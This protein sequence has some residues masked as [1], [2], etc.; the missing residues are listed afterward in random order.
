M[1]EAIR[2]SNVGPFAGVQEIVIPTG[3]VLIEGR[4]TNDPLKS[5]RAGKS[6]VLDLIRFA[7]YGKYRHDTKEKLIHRKANP[8]SDHVEVSLKMSHSI[9]DH[10]TIS[11]TYDSL[12][13]RYVITSPQIDDDLRQLKLVEQQ[14]YIDG[15][16]SCT[17]DE[18]EVSWM[19]RQ[20][21]SSGIMR[22]TLADRKTFLLDMFSPV[23]YPW[24]MWFKE[25][26]ERYS[27]LN[28]RQSDLRKQIVTA[29]ERL[30]AFDREKIVVT[31]E[32]QKKRRN[33]LT[34]LQNQY[35]R[36]VE[37]LKEQL[38]GNTVNK[39]KQEK[40]R[41]V[42]QRMEASS[43]LAFVKNQLSQVDTRVAELQKTV[44]LLEDS[45]QK[46]EVARAKWNDDDV[47]MV[48]TSV[49]KITRV[50]TEKMV[51]LKDVNS[52]INQYRSFIDKQK[53]CPVTRAICE[54]GESIQGQYVQMLSDAEQLERE[55]KQLELQQTKYQKAL[56]QW[57]L[58]AETISK[59][60]ANVSAVSSQVESVEMMRQNR[61]VLQEQFTQ[62]THELD[63]CNAA[64]EAA[65]KRVQ[66]AMQ[67]DDFVPRK[68]IQEI[69]TKIKQITQELEAID[70]SLGEMMGELKYMETV[71]ND[72]SAFQTGLAT[73]MARIDAL[74]SL[75]IALSK[76]GIPFFSLLESVHAFELEVNRALYQL[77]TNIR[78][79]ISVYRTLT[80]LEEHCHVCGYHY[81]DSKKKCI[82]CGSRRANKRQETLAIQ[83]QGLTFDVD[84][85]EDS[86][87]GMLLVS[88]AIR[89]ALFSIYRE[90]GMME[91]IDFWFLDEVFSPLDVSARNNMLQFLDELRDTYELSQLFLISHT[92]M[93]DVLQPA[94]VI[95]RDEAN[96]ESYLT[97]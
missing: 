81:K 49:T 42:K 96:E 21:D 70:H 12:S 46:L 79:S 39:L 69:S 59:L 51:M 38:A 87:G 3:I 67:K 57:E 53:V 26:N 72:I 6:Y 40:D 36:K 50:L 52:K 83:L 93:S 15:V 54:H 91:N 34:I 55:L 89:L 24:P 56:V 22:M 9:Y 80:T 74:S 90:R 25:A 13:G 10:L 30:A 11:R 48:K 97:N 7:L 17:Y 95:E 85:A 92:D 88:L 43:A 14:A 77:G 8:D 41:C 35:Q 45:E 4:Y 33:D 1:I 68:Q 65:E 29:E 18:A 37:T 23:S 32:A 94:I 19:V 62:R 64:V 73:T 2:V 86:G 71:R 58:L 16:L 27:G 76:D 78:I 63:L 28:L 31:I 66:E 47:A 20:G 84:F 75:R 5:N 61:A 82:I 44:K 60:E